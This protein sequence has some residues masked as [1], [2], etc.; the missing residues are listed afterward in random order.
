MEDI[1]TVTTTGEL[2]DHLSAYLNRA[3]FAGERVTITRNGRPSA[4][5]VSIEDLELLQRI[6]DQL[7]IA[8]ADEAV[9]EAEAEGWL[10]W[11]EVVGEP[12]P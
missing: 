8:A 9:R 1:M 6:E 3:E 2:R 5:L 7:D 12:E 4:A 10:T 11:E